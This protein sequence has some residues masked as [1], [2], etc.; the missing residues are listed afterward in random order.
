MSTAEIKWLVNIPELLG[1]GDAGLDDVDTD[2]Q[3]NVYV[4]DGFNGRVYK[5]Q[6]DSVPLDSFFVIKPAPIDKDESS[7]NIAVAADSTFYLADAGNE[8]MVRY[9]EAGMV[10][11]EFAAPGVLSLCLGVGDEINVLSNSEGI[12]RINSYD[13]LGSP[14]GMLPA[15]ARHRAYIDSGL[16]NLDSDSEGNIYISYGIPPYRIWKVKSDGSEMY[17]WSREMDFPEDAIL[18]AD[19]AVDRAAGVLWALLACRQYGR[20]MLDAFNLQG[21]FLGTVEIP[22]S[23]ALYSVICS[24]WESELYLLDA[25]AGPGTGNLIRI[26]V[27]L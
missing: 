18:I 24:A 15:P 1:L 14:L 13:Q 9:D 20:Q 4:S 11:G 26:A 2:A 3:G 16:A 19:I 23:E 22:H 12:E 5:F 21:D 6:P 27:S 17:T 7:L 25:F 10:T 8:R